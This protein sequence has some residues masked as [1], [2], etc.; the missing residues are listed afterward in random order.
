M[1]SHYLLYSIL[2]LSSF[3]LVNCVPERKNNIVSEANKRP[4][5]IAVIPKG[6][7]HAYWKSVY[8]GAYQASKETNVKIIWSS[9]KLET[10][11]DV[12]IKIIEDF[13]ASDTI[14]AIVIA[15]ADKTALV[16]P[17]EKASKK[18]IPVVII[19]SGVETESFMSFIGTD[20]Y[21]AGVACAKKMAEALKGKG[22][23]ILIRYLAYSESTNAREQGFLDAIA[24][25]AP[26]IR[27]VSADRFGGNSIASA[28]KVASELLDEFPDINGIFCPGESITVGT[29]RALE[30]KNKAEQIKLIGFDANTALFAALIEG[31]IYAIALQSP[32]DMGYEG[33]RTAAAILRKEP[34]SRINYT[35]EMLIT[36]EDLKDY[37]VK[38]FLQTQA[39]NKQ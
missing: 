11:I 9:P 14:D 10:E 24:E 22:K 26:H 25:I 6:N 1:A 3:I 37:K 36:K 27:V 33:V 23:I 38:E 17:L 21:N 16:D 39:V 30:A 34:Y 31:K 32:Y 35:D 20:N 18:N 2:A 8:N 13:I 12:Q 29:F 28:Q 19:D 5:N 4:F 7:T 15:P